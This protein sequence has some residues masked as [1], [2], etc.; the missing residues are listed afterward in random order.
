MGSRHAYIAK[1]GVIDRRG[2]WPSG[3]LPPAQGHTF[4]LPPGHDDPAL[5]CAKCGRSWFTNREDPQ[6]CLTVVTEQS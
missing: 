1:P 2:F 5:P 3:S 4:G 6:A